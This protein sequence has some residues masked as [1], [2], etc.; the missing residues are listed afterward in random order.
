[1]FTREQLLAAERREDLVKFA[2][3]NDKT[4]KKQLRRLRYE[5]E[6]YL[7]QAEMVRLQQWVARKGM[8][9]AIIFEGRDA[10]GKGGSIKRFSS[11]PAA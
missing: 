7:L 6:L 8:R 11:G 2:K 9:V 1:M 10:A 3:A 5:E 4:L